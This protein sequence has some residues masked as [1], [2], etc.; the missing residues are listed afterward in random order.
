YLASLEF[1]SIL[2]S[3]VMVKL[4]LDEFDEA[5]NP[6]MR[7]M[8]TNIVRDGSINLNFIVNPFWDFSI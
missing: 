2:V 3:W 6:K 7:I 1:G 4:P 5:K 8:T